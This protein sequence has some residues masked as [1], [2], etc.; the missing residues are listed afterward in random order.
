MAV[1]PLLRRWVPWLVGTVATAAFFDVVPAAEHDP[2]V[3]TLRDVVGYEWG[4]E[5][6]S[7]EQIAAYAA[8]FLTYRETSER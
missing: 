7:P 8:A 2:A 6:S 4:E 1:A 5:I 3:P